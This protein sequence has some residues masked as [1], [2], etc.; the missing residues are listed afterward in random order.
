MKDF[1]FKNKKYILIGVV[2][3]VVGYYIYRQGKKY[4]PKDVVLPPDIQPGGATNFNAGSF[5]D[6]VYDDVYCYFC[7]H[8]ATPYN[9]ILTLSNSELVAVYNDW[10]K[11]YFSKDNETLVAALLKESSINQIWLNAVK[12]VIERYKSLGLS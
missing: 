9:N 3:L 4:V 12:N 8:S 7:L 6:A 2:V 11:R 10:N 5:T 1:L